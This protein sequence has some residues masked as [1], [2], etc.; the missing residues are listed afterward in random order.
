LETSSTKVSAPIP[1][2]ANIEPFSEMTAL[3]RITAALELS[4][5]EALKPCHVL[6][7]EANSKLRRQSL[8]KKLDPTPSLPEQH[9]LTVFNR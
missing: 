1:A 7:K 8:P 6:M 4:G 9:S 5:R 2:D 3:E